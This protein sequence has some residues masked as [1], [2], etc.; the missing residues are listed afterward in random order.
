MDG[1]VEFLLGVKGVTLDAGS[2]WSLKWPSAPPLWVILLL[3]VP[4]GAAFVYIYYRR[5]GKTASPRARTFMALIR[6]AVFLVLAAMLFNPVV[7]VEKHLTRKSFVLILVDDSLSMEFKDRYMNEADRSRLAFA[8]GLVE[9]ERPLTPEESELFK[10]LTRM[11]LLRRVLTHK[12]K[13][14]ID[15][16]A[17]SHRLRICSFSSSLK[18]GVDLTNLRPVGRLTK[19]GDSLLE[20]VVELKG[21]IVAAVI[22]FSDGCENAGGVSAVDAARRL[23]ALDVPVRVFPVGVGSPDEPRDIE[24][25]NPR[26]AETILVG[27]EW[28]VNV[29]L[30]QNGYDL[31][32]VMLV[33]K[34]GEE[35]CVEQ[36]ACLGESGLEQEERIVYKPTKPGRYTFTVEVPVQENETILENNEVSLVLNVVDDKIRVLYVDTYPRWEYRRLKNAL[37]RDKGMLVN[38]LLLEADYNYPQ[39][40]S[41]DAKVEE[42]ACFPTTKKELFGFDV[43][44]FGDVNPE[45]HPLIF[46]HP[47][48]QMEWLEEFVRVM[49]GGFVLISGENSAPRIFAGTPVESLLPVILPSG[50]E[51]AAVSAQKDSMLPVLTPRGRDHP[52]MRLHNDPKLNQRLWTDEEFG[53]P[54]FYWHVAGLREKP[55]ATVLARHRED[56]R[57]TPMPEHDVLFAFQHYGAGKTFLS[58]VD[59]TW[60]W[61]YKYGDSR[62]YRF[63]RQVIKFVGQ[64]RLLGEKKRFVLT[65]DNYEYV[66][67]D[68]VKLTARILDENFRPSIKASQDIMLEFPN[69]EKKKLTLREVAGARGTYDTVLTLTQLGLHHAFIEESIRSEKPRRLGEVTFRVMVPR[70]EFEN[71]VMNRADLKTV[72]DLS[73]GELFYLPGIGAIP[74]KID[75]R[76]QTIRGVESV[77]KLW[78]TLILFCIFVGLLCVE[79]VYRKRRQLL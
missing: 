23:A 1:I 73:K 11:D 26:A 29:T 9:Q 30:R 33:L 51:V 62:F 31:T 18:P 22:L 37:I 43:V 78:D 17:E 58:A 72:A 68:T 32:N 8:A 75:R 24:V 67:G 14:F 44:I 25:K 57:G 79:W 3:I 69:G 52:L 45:M 61:C 19:I 28:E 6:L 10:N 4:A 65:A 15:V 2:Q 36:D 48:K 56:P 42:M 7:A 46:P 63:W 74:E 53:L 35:V 21:Q 55:G 77:Y 60:R 49:G 70:R 64:Q 71:P 47:D 12:Q 76:E 5:E 13:E 59:S 50:D 41:S 39:E 27:D 20:A 40:K 66:V 38:C 16:L 54:G 34:C